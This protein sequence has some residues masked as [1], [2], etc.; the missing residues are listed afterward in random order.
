[1]SDAPAASHELKEKKL[2]KKGRKLSKVFKD[3]FKRVEANA[4]SFEPE[5]SAQDGTSEKLARTNLPHLHESLGPITEN[6]GRRNSSLSGHSL[7]TGENPTSPSLEPASQSAI[8]SA[9]SA[10]QSD[11]GKTIRASRQIGE[12]IPPIPTKRRQSLDFNSRA[13]SPQNLKRSSSLWAQQHQRQWVLDDA[14]GEFQ[15]RYARNFGTGTMSERQRALN[16]KRARKM[17]QVFGQEPPS[18]LIHINDERESDH[19]RDSTVTLSTS[20]AVTPPLRNRANSTSSSGTMATGD[21]A[22]AEVPPTPPP[23]STATDDA[24][25]ASDS[26]PTDSFQD[27][28]RR[29]AKLSRFFGVGFRDILQSPETVPLP[30]ARVQVDVKVTG[31]RFWGFND[32]SKNDDMEEAIQKLRGLKAS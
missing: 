29:A 10:E 5:P 12:N 23:F 17:A 9:D 14:A 3:D 32:R 1:M 2:F 7:L 30:D 24:P 16:V 21:E 15:E 27:R 4:R 13:A 25:E 8:P 20:L 31:R 6:N 11:K 22:E 28:R 18:E 26:A 19:F